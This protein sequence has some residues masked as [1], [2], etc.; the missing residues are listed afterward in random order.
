MH[1]CKNMTAPSQ[2]TWATECMA[3]AHQHLHQMPSHLLLSRGGLPVSVSLTLHVVLHITSCVLDS[4]L[5]LLQH[6]LLIQISSPPQLAHPDH[7]QLKK[8]TAQ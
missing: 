6:T 2:L 8:G 7:R 5:S 3:A 4:L 1:I